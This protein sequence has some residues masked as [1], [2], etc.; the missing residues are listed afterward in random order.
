MS[1]RSAVE[2]LPDPLALI[3][4]LSFSLWVGRKSNQGLVDTSGCG[5]MS[6]ESE[7]SGAL[8]RLERPTDLLDPRSCSHLVGLVSPERLD[9]CASGSAA[10]GNTVEF[11]LDKI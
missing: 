5:T 9:E 3:L 11:L 8:H 4:S 2:L 1:R 10:M 7:D 6:F